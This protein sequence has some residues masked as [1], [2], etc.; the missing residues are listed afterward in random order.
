MRIL[1]WYVCGSGHHTRIPKRVDLGA[2]SPACLLRGEL[3][4]PRQ[5][6]RALE[7]I[8]AKA[9][10]SGPVWLTTPGAIAAH[11]NATDCAV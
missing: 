2:F 7:H 1:I 3:T 9:Q 5:L 11:V 6:R 8:A 4:R 10:G